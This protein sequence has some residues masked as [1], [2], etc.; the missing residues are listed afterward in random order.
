MS[1]SIN[2]V[3]LLG[4]LGQDPEVRHTQSNRRIVH[5]SVATA[6]SWKD[7]DS[8]EKC[9][10]VEWHRVVIFNEGLAEVAERYLACGSRVYL[11]GALQTRKWQD[12]EGHDRLTTEI[13]LQRYRGELVLLGD[14]RGTMPAEPEDEGATGDHDDAA[15]PDEDGPS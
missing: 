14:G 15:V 6:Q 2:K 13:V 9:Q 8:G 11:E 12:H 10:R 7:R 4:H 1:G 3:T 5:L